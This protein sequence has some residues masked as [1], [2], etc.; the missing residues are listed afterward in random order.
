MHPVALLFGLACGGALIASMRGGSAMA[1]VLAL[2]LGIVWASANILWLLDAMAW[3]PLVDLPLACLTY[4]VWYDERRGW[5][6]SL[7]TIYAIRLPLHLLSDMGA[8]GDTTYKHLI[9]ALFLAALVSVA[10]EGGIADL[11]SGCRRWLRRLRLSPAA[12]VCAL[13][14][15]GCPPR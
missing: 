6:A 7:A 8:V 5:Q 9:N 1:Q 11:A 10:W 2:L 15:L 12:S 14:G 13:E 3:L 4:A